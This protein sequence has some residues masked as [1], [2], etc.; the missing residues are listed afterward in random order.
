MKTIEIVTHCWAERDWRYAAAL[1]YQLSSLALHLPTRCEVRVV[2]C[3]R[4][5]DS[6]VE[7]TINHF[8]KHLI[9]SSLGYVSTAWV[10]RRSIGRNLAAKITE[11]DV[12][13]FADCD[14][15]FGEGALDYLADFPW[16]GGETIVYPGSVKISPTHEI[17]DTML[18]SAMVLGIVVG[19]G[20][21]V[22]CR[23]ELYKRAIGGCQIVEGDF[24]RQHGYL[25]NTKWQ[26]PTNR[27]FGNKGHG[28]HTPEDVAYRQFCQQHGLMRSLDIPNVFRIRHSEEV[29][30]YDAMAEKQN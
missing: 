25:D 17:G 19:I 18:R 4:H 30:P 23:V 5:G 22:D 2:V 6:L 9:L 1:R 16:N 7:D 21:E 27:P 28:T 13:W 15:C 3:Y 10:G 20:E 8:N 12:V 26:K 14:Y 11:A 29:I 24:A